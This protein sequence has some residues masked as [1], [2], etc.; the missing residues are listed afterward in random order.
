MSV[1]FRRSVM[2]LTHAA[3]SSSP[4]AGGTEAAHTGRPVLPGVVLGL[5]M[6]I[7]LLVVAFAWPASRTAPRDL[8][9][10][11]VAPAAVATQVQQ[12]MAQAHPGAFQ[13][14]RFGST[15]VAERAIRTREVYGALV[16]A[17]KPEV[18]TASAASPVVAQLLDQAATERAGSSAGQSGGLSA[19]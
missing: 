5:S 6:L 11:L 1:R 8:P 12:Q 17:P 3:R 15:A 18:L 14:T 13:V 4:S 2:E 9:V 7:T 16:L 10:A 19:G